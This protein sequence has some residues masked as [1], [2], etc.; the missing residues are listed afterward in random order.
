[1]KS[2]QCKYPSITVQLTGQNGNAF[3]IISS[4]SKAIR[5]KH[6][7]ASEEFVKAAFACPS[8]DALLAL[9]SKWVNVT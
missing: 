1:M 5:S 3:A 6:G 4:V 8:Y 9:C 7:E 2:P